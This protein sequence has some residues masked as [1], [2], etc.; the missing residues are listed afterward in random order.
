MKGVWV[1]LLATCCA[2]SV[3]EAD[4][5]WRVKGNEE[6][7][8]TTSSTTTTRQTITE[9]CENGGTHDGIKCLCLSNFYGPKC[10]FPVEDMP[11]E[12]ESVPVTIEVQVKITNKEFVPELEN[13]ESEEYK[14][15]EEEFKM[16]MDN[17]YQGVSGYQGVVILKLR[18]GSIIV[19]HEV[20]IKAVINND[21][22]IIDK[23]VQNLT[24]VVRKQLTA[25]N[26][27]QE[28]CNTGNSSFC[29]SAS[30]DPILSASTNFSAEAACR[31]NI[32]PRYADYYYPDNSTGTLR[33]ISNCTKDTKNTMNCNNGLC[34]LSE[35]GPYC[36]CNDVESFWYMDD[37]CQTPIRKSDV[38]FGVGLAVLAVISTILAIFLLRARWRKS[39]S[40]FSDDAEAWYEEDEEEWKPSGGLTIVNEGAANEESQDRNRSFQ[41]SLDSVDTTTQMQFQKPTAL[42][43]Y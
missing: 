5:S 3:A 43:N 17:V 36:R 16:Q 4:V 9:T 14:N 11:F 22:N 7:R 20:I 12:V 38:G 34:S 35:R 28:E 13:Q 1:L 6:E 37:R 42:T 31:K 26:S 25:V 40:S 30:P 32:D 23:T 41:V 18:K 29:F 10:E 15:L 21:V 27:T 33:C 24:E 39:R 8:V 19:D 2:S